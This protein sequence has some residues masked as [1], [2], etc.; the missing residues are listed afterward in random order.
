MDLGSLANTS[1]KFSSEI[2]LGA[3]FGVAH[4]WFVGVN[5]FNTSKG[6]T[7]P[8]ESN[9]NVKY[10]ATSRVSVGGFYIPKYDSF[11]SYISR[12]TY[13]VGAR[14]EDT[15]IVLNN[16]PIEDFGITFGLG[17]P[18]GGLSKINVGVELGQL[19]TLNGGLI[20]ENYTNIMLGFSLS[21]IWF[22][23]RKYD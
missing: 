19:G 23:K 22:I 21:D 3:G 5:F 7:N 17:L 13:R 6:H 8:L 14:F 1:N 12:V 16:Q 10:E 2:N 18:V 15:G 20:K 11:T 4:K 9:A